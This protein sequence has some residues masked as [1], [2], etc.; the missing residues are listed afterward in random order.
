M[1]LT[2]IGAVGS[3]DGWSVTVSP[4]QLPAPSNP[5]L[6]NHQELVSPTLPTH[7]AFVCAAGNDATRFARDRFAHRTTRGQAL[8]GKLG[9]YRPPLVQWPPVHPAIKKSHLRGSTG[10]S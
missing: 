1:V 6:R 7:V 2:P 3:C 8:I 5:L 4:S 10:G 9:Q